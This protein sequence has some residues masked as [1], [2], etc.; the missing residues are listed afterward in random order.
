MT[1]AKMT[2]AA[3]ARHI[4]VSRQS[5]HKWANSGKIPVSDDG[6]IPVKDA[7]FALG[8]GN[9]AHPSKVSEQILRARVLHETYRAKAAKLAYEK[10]LANTLCADDV[11]GA[12]AQLGEILGREIDKLEA[13]AQAVTKAAK[14]GGAKTL[15]PLLKE[16]SRELRQTMA[17]ALMASD[18]PEQMKEL[19]K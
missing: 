7:E 18:G 6:A 4:G 10:A 17:D 9:G 16:I 8:L 5:V 19:P 12:M 15:R 1:P 14:A 3:F 11:A 13:Y 2:K